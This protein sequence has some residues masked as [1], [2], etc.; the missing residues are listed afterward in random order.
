MHVDALA[1]GELDDAEH[2]HVLV[3]R[4]RDVDLVD[5]AR[6]RRPRRSGR[7]CRA[8]AGRGSRSR[9]SSPARSST[10]PTSLKPSSLC[11]RMRSATIRPR[12]PTPTIST[13]LQ[14]DAGAP[15]AAQQVAHDLARGVGEERR[16]APRNST[17]TPREIARKPCALSASLG[18]RSVTYSVPRRRRA[19]AEQAADEHARRSRRRACGRGA[20]D[21]APAAGTRAAR[22]AR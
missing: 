3:E 1:A 10:K 12:S 19:R 18:G 8:A 22:A 6:A 4:Q 2:L 21:R 5:A 14:A 7:S 17:Q 15:A 13:R 20:A 16:S 9:R 11:S